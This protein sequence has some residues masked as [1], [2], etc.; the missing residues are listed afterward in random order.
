MLG[1]GSQ[2]Q[3]EGI[4]LQVSVFEEQGELSART[5]WWK[6][7]CRMAGHSATKVQ[8]MFKGT[9]QEP[10]PSSENVAFRTQSFKPMRS[11]GGLHGSG[12]NQCRTFTLTVCDC[13]FAS[14]ELNL[15][16]ISAGTLRRKLAAASHFLN[17][18]S[19]FAITLPLSQLGCSVGFRGWTLLHFTWL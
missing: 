14:F 6:G 16:A 13:E 9:R 12:R 8:H 5:R 10:P 18:S 11:N 19:S 17:S 7:A 15:S 1:R 3:W 2:Q 4:G